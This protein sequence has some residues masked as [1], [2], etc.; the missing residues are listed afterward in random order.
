MTQKDFNLRILE[1][2]NEAG[3]RFASH[4]FSRTP[5]AYTAAEISKGKSGKGEPIDYF[6][7]KNIES[8]SVE[9]GAFKAEISIDGIFGAIWNFE[10][11]CKVKKQDKCKFC[12]G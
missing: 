8:I 6:Y 5:G 11:L 9:V 4:T 3:K 1:K 7:V 2:L 10:K 12:I